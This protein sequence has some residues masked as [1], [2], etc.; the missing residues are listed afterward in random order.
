M[1]ITIGH[2][3]NDNKDYNQVLLEQNIQIKKIDKDWDLLKFSH[4]VNG[5]FQSKLMTQ[6]FYSRST[7][8]EMLKCPKR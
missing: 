1:F 6:G 7:F 8:T 5:M 4:T 3:S 2:K